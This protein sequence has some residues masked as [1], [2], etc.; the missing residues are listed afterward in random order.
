VNV[1]ER[2]GA[3]GGTDGA[4]RAAALA[5]VVA[6]A[7]LQLPRRLGPSACMALEHM[8]LCLHRTGRGWGRP[9]GSPRLR[10]PHRHQRRH[11][12]PCHLNSGHRRA[13]Y[14][15]RVKTPG[16]RGRSGYLRDLPE[17]TWRIRCP[18]ELDV[19]E[20]RPTWCPGGN[21]PARPS[22][23]LAV[24]PIR[25]LPSTMP[26]ERRGPEPMPRRPVGLSRCCRGAS[27]P[28]S[29]H[30]DRMKPSRCRQAGRGDERGTHP[31]RTKRPGAGR[32]FAWS[33]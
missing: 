28:Y 30:R 10:R 1:K 17:H 26:A 9:G 18:D 14:V 15:D 22:R 8:A 33:L 25:A 21:T 16:V 23:V 6:A 20:G 2:G 12:R 27:R 24:F 4:G 19:T 13:G 7:S 3:T 32:R 5:L 31:G 29:T 11:R